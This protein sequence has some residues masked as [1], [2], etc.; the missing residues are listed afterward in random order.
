VRDVSVDEL[1][2]ADEILL[3]STAGGPIGVSRL[4][5]RILNNDRPGPLSQK[6]RET[7][8]AKRKA[9]WHADP[10]DYAAA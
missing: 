4:D 7:Y 5:G 1:R 3:S 9:G 6:I 10:I 8:W 2:D